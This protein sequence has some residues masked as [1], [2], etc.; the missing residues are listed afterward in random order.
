MIGQT[1]YVD[2]AQAAKIASVS[3]KTI[4]RA[5]HANRLTDHESKPNRS[6]IAVD[7]LNGYIASR[8]STQMD[9]HGHVHVDEKEVRIAELESTVSSLQQYVQDIENKRIAAL[10]TAMQEM[11]R[12]ISDLRILVEQ[13][14]HGH[15]HTQVGAPMQEPTA[16][17]EPTEEKPKRRRTTKQQEPA[18]SI[19]DFSKFWQD[20]YESTAIHQDVKA[21]VLLKP[22]LGNEPERYHVSW[23]DWEPTKVKRVIPDEM[24]ERGETLRDS[25]LAAAHESLVAAGWIVIDKHHRYK[26]PD[27]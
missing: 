1:E 26:L 9:T 21:K 4:R 22:S 24:K 2:I 8:E 20:K 5:I 18:F 23:C 7:E 10:E 16:Q 15:G 25:L 14:G 27:A 3:T 19:A 6:K 13:D 11:A 17:E 12:E